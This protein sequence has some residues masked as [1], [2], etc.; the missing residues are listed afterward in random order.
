MLVPFKL[1]LG[2]RLGTGAQW[3][4]WITLND[5]VEA[6]LHL[7]GAS[8][9]S[10]AVNLAAPNPVTNAEFTRVLGQVLGRPARLAVPAA[11]L[12]LVL[13]SEMAEQLML[14]S[15]R[16]LPVVLERSGYRFS[17]TQLEGAL[18]SL[19]ARA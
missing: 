3:W 2:G 12:R 8:D 4:S 19:L 14:A 11:A 17:H 5:E 16:A 10:G 9:V 1:G 7:M 18:R 15:Q 13:G 6:L